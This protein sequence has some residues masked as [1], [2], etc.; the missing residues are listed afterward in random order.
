MRSIAIAIG[1]FVVCTTLA[2]AQT[3]QT[4]EQ[5]IRALIAKYD[6]GQ[7]QGMAAKDRIFW[8][9]AIK[10]PVIGAQQGEEVPD[11]TRASD[12]RPGTQRITSDN[13]PT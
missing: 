10:R 1:F 7:T 5:Q 13:C 2:G 4:D 11:D 12:R 3:T 8:S 6:A 9:G